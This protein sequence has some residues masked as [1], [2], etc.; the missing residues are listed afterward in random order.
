M[1]GLGIV[2]VEFSYVIDSFC[3]WSL[4]VS[5]QL[6]FCNFNDVIFWPIRYF[7]RCSHNGRLV[8]SSIIVL[9]FIFNSGLPLGSQSENE[10][11]SSGLPLIVN[12]YLTAFN[13]TKIE[14]RKKVNRNAFWHHHQNYV[15]LEIRL[16]W[17]INDAS[18]FMTHEFS[19]SIWLDERNHGAT[20]RVTIRPNPD[21][22]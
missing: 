11:Q 1:I 12:Q 18:W 6:F 3:I 9:R 19:V 22:N 7:Q 20:P 10:I 13:Q 14:L 16:W 5:K 15:F 4:N 2:Y 21:W 8:H 17:V